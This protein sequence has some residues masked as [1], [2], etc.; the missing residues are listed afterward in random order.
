[1]YYIPGK[2][3]GFGERTESCEVGRFTVLWE[4]FVFVKG[5][6]PGRPSIDSFMTEIGRSNLHRAASIL[7]GSFACFVRDKE[8]GNWYVFCDGSRAT[9]VFYTED[10]VSSSFLELA[11]RDHL[12]IDDMNPLSVVEFILTGLQFSNKTFF[13][14]IKMLDTQ[15]ILKIT[16][17][18]LIELEHLENRDPFQKNP[19]SDLQSAFLVLMEKIANSIRELRV[20]VDLTGGTDSRLTASMLDH[21]R[22]KFETSVSGASNQ[23]DILISEKVSR[24]LKPVN[25]HHSFVHEVDPSTLWLE[26]NDIVRKV[27]GLCD[28]VGA[29]RLYQF[30]LDREKRG[31]ELA[32]GS[33]GGE[34]YKDSGF[35]RTA[36]L[37]PLGTKEHYINKIVTSGVASWGMHAIP[38]GILSEKLKSLSEDYISVVKEHLRERFLSTCTS[39]YELADRLFYEYSVR[40][41]RG[42]ACRIIHQYVPYLDPELVTIGTHLSQQNRF[43]HGFHRKILSKLSPKLAN[44]STTRAGLSMAIGGRGIIRDGIGILRRQLSHGKIIAKDDPKLYLYLRARPEIEDVLVSMKDHSIIN[45]DIHLDEISDLYLGRLVTLFKTFGSS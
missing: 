1:M 8:T 23:E 44:L 17:G 9:P 39:K 36:F 41:P 38:S 14:Q 7:S 22:L 43:R 20:S 11:H 18:H 13:D 15:E 6:K 37:T 21:F 30:G 45:P 4:G 5:E 2:G 24:V 40:A 26:L 31:I 28:A 32:I 29:H 16:P 3:I 42:F 10:A 34:L 33:S 27:D 25:G 35:W 12:G 19:P